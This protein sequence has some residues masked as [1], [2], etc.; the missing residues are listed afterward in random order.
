MTALNAMPE[1]IL[2]D[3][4]SSLPDRRTAERRVSPAVG[5]F[6]INECAR[7]RAIKTDL[8][9]ALIDLRERHQIDEPHHADLCDHCRMADAAI[10]AAQ[11]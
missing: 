2:A 6:A 9:A 5:E 10:A 4:L 8:L 11:P 3:E 1:R 7:L